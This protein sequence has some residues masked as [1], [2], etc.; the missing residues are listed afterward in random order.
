MVAEHGLDLMCRDD[1]VEVALTGPVTDG[2]CYSPQEWEVKQVCSIL[3]A[4]EEEVVMGLWR[5]Q[6]EALPPKLKLVI[7]S[8]L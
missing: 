7:P 8:S 2:D 5:E 4:W 1:P 3:E 6:F